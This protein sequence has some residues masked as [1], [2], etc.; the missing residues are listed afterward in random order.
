MK[1]TLWT[2]ADALLVLTLHILL[3]SSKPA[4]SQ[5]P[6]TIRTKCYKILEDQVLSNW[7][8]SGTAPLDPIITPHRDI[9]SKSPTFDS[10]TG[11]WYD[12]P[13]VTHLQSLAISSR[14]GAG[15][16]L[17]HLYHSPWYIL[18]NKMYSPS[19]W[20][21]SRSRI[22]ATSQIMFQTNCGI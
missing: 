16:L 19:R 14:S 11:N 15:L 8:N 7:P 5:I 4:K 13:L 6:N 21:S 18:R 17:H 10:Q 3:H 9:L 20:Q 12:H 22:F 1:F 2:F